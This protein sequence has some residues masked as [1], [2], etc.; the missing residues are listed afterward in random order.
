[1]A[2]PAGGSKRDDGGAEAEFFRVAMRY[3]PPDGKPPLL[4]SVNRDKC[5]ARLIRVEARSLGDEGAALPRRQH[6]KTHSSWRDSLSASLTG[7]RKGLAK[8]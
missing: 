5:I 3:Q 1:M 7:A 8:S 6:E 4:S 2:A